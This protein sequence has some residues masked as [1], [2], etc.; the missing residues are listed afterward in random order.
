MTVKRNL[1]GVVGSLQCHMSSLWY[2]MDK[3][4]NC[5]RTL[6]TLA[7][8]AAVATITLLD[9]F[10]EIEWDDYPNVKNW[11]RIQKPSCKCLLREQIAGIV[12]RDRYNRLAV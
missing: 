8:T 10:S 2:M 4:I 12:P 5:V 6:Y 9:H 1:M 3:Q 7:D 11:Y